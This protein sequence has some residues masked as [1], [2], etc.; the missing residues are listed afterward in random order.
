[1]QKCFTDYPLYPSEFG[2]EAPVR[3]VDFISYDGNKYC[4]VRYQN[5]YFE[6]KSGYLYSEPKR[7]EDSPNKF[8]VIDSNTIV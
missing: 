6:I 3:E 7:L 8:R 4:T 5:Q 2:K 1:M